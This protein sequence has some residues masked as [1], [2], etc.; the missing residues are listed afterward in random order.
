VGNDSKAPYILYSSVPELSYAKKINNIKPVSYFFTRP[1]RQNDFNYWNDTTVSNYSITAYFKMHFE[2]TFQDGE[3]YYM[4]RISYDLR[5]DKPYV[6]STGNTKE[7]EEKIVTHKK[8]GNLID[9]DEEAFN[10]AFSEIP[11][12]VET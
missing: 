12:E 1:G 4:A 11:S 6:Q 8:E 2:K 7:A 9:K 3:G 5:F 10:Q